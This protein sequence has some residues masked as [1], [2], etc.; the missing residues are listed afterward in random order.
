MSVQILVGMIASGKSTYCRWAAKQGAIIVNDDAVV[1]AV[2]A[3]HYELY[4]KSLKVLYKST[5]NHLVTMG[6]AL[7]KTVV[8]DCARNLNPKT[9]KRWIALAQIF[10]TP[11][12]AIVFPSE[13]PSIHASRRMQSDSRGY[14]FEYWRQVAEKHWESYQY[15]AMTEGFDTI[16]AIT[17]ED[18]QKGT[19]IWNNLN[20]ATQPST[21]D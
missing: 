12:I 20:S 3:N 11:C 19:L 9:R 14:S 17:F 8:V 21:G 15:P 1:N 16:H 2:H 4:D 6:L 10:D 5:E 13:I 7:G 18:M